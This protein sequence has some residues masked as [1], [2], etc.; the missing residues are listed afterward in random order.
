MLIKKHPA[1]CMP[2]EKR[3]TPK[4]GKRLEHNINGL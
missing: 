3:H 2:K 1:G 4:P